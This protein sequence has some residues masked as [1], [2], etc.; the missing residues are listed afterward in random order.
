MSKP[1][2][3][4]LYCGAGGAAMGYYRAGFDEIVGVDIA[5][6]KHYPFTF[7]QADGLSYI[8]EHGH[9]FDAIHASPPCQKFTA[10]RTMWNSREHEDQL[11]PTRALL[12]QIGKPY[13]IENV[14]GAPMEGAWVRLCGS[15]FALG[16]GS[17]ELRRHRQFELGGFYALTPPCSHYSRPLAVGVY[18]GGGKDNR[19]TIGV[20]GDGNGRDYRRHPATVLVT[21]HAGGASVRDGVQ[22][23]T[24]DERREAMGIDWMT[25]DE[26]SQA[27]PPAY[28]RYIGTW[29]LAA[30]E[31]EA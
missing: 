19:R 30:V 29:L 4:D 3:L 12:Q 27:I 10:L 6:Q 13:V 8:R 20:Y 26:L 22:Q 31:A 23:F 7:V 25:G 1:R 24:T 9:E 21:G 16:V 17:A 14:P 15:M 11:T 18:G 2:L 5:P 28:T